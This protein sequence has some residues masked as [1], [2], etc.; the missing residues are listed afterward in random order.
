MQQ[1]IERTLGYPLPKRKPLAAS[2]FI[3]PVARA[4]M[5]LQIINGKK[6]ARAV[7][8]FLFVSVE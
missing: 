2:L 8:Y 7:F 3:I 1:H 6:M 4:T 5:E